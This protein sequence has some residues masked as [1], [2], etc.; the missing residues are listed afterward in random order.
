MR[1]HSL[2]RQLRNS[3]RRN[4]PEFMAYCRARHPHFVFQ[5]GVTNIRDEI[6]VFTFHSVEPT[7]FE[8]QLQFLKINGY[9]TVTTNEFYEMI[10]GARRIPE[11]SVMLTFDDGLG[12]V[13]SIAFPLLKKY[14]MTAVCFII[15]GCISRERTYYPN[16]ED[17]WEQNARLHDVM[18][19]ESS[20]R[21]FCSWDEIRVMHE[22][23][24]IDFQS[25]TLYHNL[26]YC[27]STIV[28]Y[29]NP[30][31]AGWH[32]NLCVPMFTIKGKENIERTVELGTPLYES[33]PRMAGQRR[34]YDDEHLRDRLVQYVRENGNE[35]FFKD[36]AWR[37]KLRSTL[38]KCKQKNALIDECESRQALEDKL[39]DD[40]YRARRLI[41]ARLSGK[42]VRHLCYPWF[43]G[44]DLAMEISKKAGY[45]TN[46]WG[47]LPRRRAN[48]QGAD[49]FRTV[50]V[51]EEY[52]YR[53]P[54]HGRK[55][56][57]Q[58]V[59]DIVSRSYN[60]FLKKVMESN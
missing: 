59:E 55:S 17:H 5:R 8:A 31:F 26:E 19:R 35:E 37:R 20:E 32:G 57:Y 21:P 10:T 4:I 51:R 24:V 46:V 52:M 33:K 25:H 39:Y 22:S 49:P 1:L 47:T 28:D 40:L 29:M 23:G 60:V 2:T 14:K 58:V 44:S 13:W 16:L 53:L 12:S 27:S 18:C 42:S 54:G 36:R 11:R 45:V 38:E 34:Y 3:Y 7:R 50:R 30:K 48:R 41:E 9:H 15:P 6:P 43:V 56:L